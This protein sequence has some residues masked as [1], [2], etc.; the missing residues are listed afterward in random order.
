[1]IEILNRLSELDEMTLGL[2]PQNPADR[3]ELRQITDEMDRLE[4]LLDEINHI[5]WQNCEHGL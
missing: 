2:D 1:M 4:V 5:E 3:D